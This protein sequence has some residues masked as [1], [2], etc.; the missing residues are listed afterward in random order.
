M[1]YWRK[2]HGTTS[3]F[4]LEA[5]LRDYKVYIFILSIKFTAEPDCSPT[6][7]G[8]PLKKTKTFWGVNNIVRFFSVVHI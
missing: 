4:Y 3:V 6:P 7:A 1:F 5:K 2:Y 8:C